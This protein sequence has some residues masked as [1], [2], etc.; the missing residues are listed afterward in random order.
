MEEPIRE[1]GGDSLPLP[2]VPTL[3]LGLYPPWTFCFH[4]PSIHNAIPYS[5]PSRQS[6]LSCPWTPETLSLPLSD[7]I[8][9][10]RQL[11]QTWQPWE[12]KEDRKNLN[13][14][15]LGCS[16]QRFQALRPESCMVLETSLVYLSSDPPP[17]F[18][19]LRFSGVSIPKMEPQWPFSYLSGI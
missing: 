15:G 10:G 1:W 7:R 18:L 9:L 16:G 12:C 14:W 17:S 19:P 8:D 4:N 13:R 3:T 5:F 11:G 6:L 2:G